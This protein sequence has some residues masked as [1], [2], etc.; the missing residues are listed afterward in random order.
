VTHWLTIDPDCICIACPIPKCTY[1]SCSLH[2]P[3]ISDSP[4]SN[5]FI[6]SKIANHHIVYAFHLK[7]LSVP[8]SNSLMR[9]GSGYKQSLWRINSNGKRWEVN[10]AISLAFLYDRWTIVRGCR[11]KF[12]LL[13]CDGLTRFTMSDLLSI[14]HDIARPN[15]FRTRPTY[16]QREPERSAFEHR[17]SL[18]KRISQK[19]QQL[20]S[21]CWRF[22]SHRWR[23]V[24]STMDLG[25][26]SILNCNNKGPNQWKAKLSEGLLC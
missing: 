19:S 8:R 14:L 21:W 13:A 4:F 20:H 23:A 11:F 5:Y 10:R 3:L 12:L 24:S 7:S 6:V 22:K 9:H 16:E 18:G 26:V 25:R 17:F 1:I 15:K 2:D